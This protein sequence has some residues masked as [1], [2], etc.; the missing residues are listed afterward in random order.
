[1]SIYKHP[2][3]KAIQLQLYDQKLKECNINYEEIYVDT[4]A[5]KTHILITGQNDKPPIIVLHGIHAGAPLALE[6]IKGL[7]NRFRIYAIDTIGQATK[8]DEN[9]LSVKGNDYAKWLAE[10]M[11]KLHIKSAPIIGVSY[12]AFILQNMMVYFP[13]FIAKALFVVPAGFAKGE[14]ITSMKKLTLPLVQFLL[15]KKDSRLLQFMEAFYTTT[16][17]YSV[18]FQRNILLGIKMDFNQPPILRQEQVQNFSQAV[19][20]MVAEDDVF[21]P[22]KL[23]VEKCQSIFSNFKDFHILKNNK[24]IPDPKTYPEIEKKLQEWLDEK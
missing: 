16:D 4:F 9:Q 7:R 18:A 19:Y 15:F 23:S 1:M 21:F 12:G 17:D 10:T 8:S 13:S 11:E 6:A 14:F 20:I 5:G 22:G 3:A 24:H 2:E